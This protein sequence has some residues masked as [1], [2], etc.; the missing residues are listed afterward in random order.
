MYLSRERGRMSSLNYFE[1][2]ICN[3]AHGQSYFCDNKCIPRKLFLFIE[4]DTRQFQN[5]S[6][7]TAINKS[8]AIPILLFNLS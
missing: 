6:L 5:C 3:L 8:A 4:N 7:A 2:V 1:K